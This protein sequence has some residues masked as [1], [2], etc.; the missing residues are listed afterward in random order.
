MKEEISRCDERSCGKQIL[1]KAFY[2]EAFDAQYAAVDTPPE[3]IYQ[4]RLSDLEYC[5]AHCLLTAINDAI[6]KALLAGKKET[7]E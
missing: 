4:A 5:G 1:G 7:H 6:N 3:E 2:L